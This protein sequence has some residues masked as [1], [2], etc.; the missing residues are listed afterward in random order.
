MLKLPD[1]GLFVVIDDEDTAERGTYLRGVAASDP[2][3][4]F[5]AITPGSDNN[6]TVGI[7]IL[8]A[9]G[10][11][12]DLV[13]AGRN[14]AETWQRAALWLELANLSDVFVSR[15]HLLPY[16]LMEDLVRLAAR[17][18]TRLWLIFQTPALQRRHVR[19]LRLWPVTRLEWGEFQARWDTPSRKRRRTSSKPT[20]AAEQ[21]RRLPHVPIDDFTT[22]RAACRELLSADDFALV[23]AE[24]LRAFQ[25]T[26]AY[27][28][29]QGGQA[30]TE[31]TICAHVREA[32]ADLDWMPTLTTRIRGSQVAAFHAGYLVKANLDALMTTR[33]SRVKLDDEVLAKLSRYC[34]PRFA[35]AAVL[36]AAIDC[37]LED[38]LALNIGDVAVGGN[39]VT[40]SG[41]T[42]RLPPEAGR[43]VEGLARE[44]LM[45]EATSE[46]P[47]F[48]YVPGTGRKH[49]ARM[50][51]TVR[52]MSD[53]LKKLERE[54]GVLLTAHLRDHGQRNAVSWAQRRGISIQ[55]I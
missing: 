36:V 31:E 39:M 43:L 30:V 44:R 21:A 54:T 26:S 33:A 52:G 40:V 22:F 24:F 23:D 38:L 32:I 50:R 11:D 10:K 25:T 4:L 42:H 3:K 51:W 6:R 34:T 27:L 45:Q 20:R 46:E 17:A 5:V 29:S 12:P 1:P 49:G 2:D 55:R 47:L 7:D 53:N 8:R 16:W 41:A 48:V 37:Q 18:Q 19:F 15:A 9:L 14:S 35:A 28:E 13:G